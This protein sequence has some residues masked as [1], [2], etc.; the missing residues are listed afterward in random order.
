MKAIIK[1]DLRSI[2]SNKRM[3]TV[4][5]VVPFV[6]SVIL[7]CS[8]MFSTEV[9][10]QLNLILNYIMPL[11]FIMIPISS[12]SVMAAGSFVGE[13]EKRTLETLFY[14]PL[15][16]KD[17]FGAKILAAFL[18]S[19]A[20]SVFSFVIILSVIFIFAKTAALPNINWLI[21][22][23]L[24]SPAASL[25]SINLIVRSSAKAQSAEESQQS[26]LLLIMPLIL[27]I[28]GQFSGVMM[29][30]THIFLILGVVMAIIAVFM[31]K[32]SYAKF[33]YEMLMK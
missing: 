2:T 16:L 26:S 11:F 27:F 29:M 30:G 20:I 25:I 18:L 21:T 17:I 9:F 6:M 24:V 22:L 10:M 23:F 7:P 15:S 13:K 3:M 31:F 8:L 4:L 19:M 12:A 28:I 1:K 5:I 14:S 33:K 32:S